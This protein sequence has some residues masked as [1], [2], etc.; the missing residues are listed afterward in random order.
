MGKGMDATQ[1]PSL[2]RI[3]SS[4]AASVARVFTTVRNVASRVKVRRAERLLR[5]CE[6]LPLGDRRFLLLVQCDQRR[7][8]IGASAH[9]ITLIDRLD[10]SA[11]SAL[12][13][14]PSAEKVPWKDLH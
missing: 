10:E 14:I 9:A 12:D 2:S 6:T 13:E 11:D 4:L 1:K 5:V 3:A 8:L 7:Y